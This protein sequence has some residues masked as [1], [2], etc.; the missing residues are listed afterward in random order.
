MGIFSP[1][2]HNSLDTA[3]ENSTGGGLNEATD[4]S[5]ESSNAGF[6]EIPIDNNSERLGNGSNSDQDFVVVDCN[7]EI[8]S[9]QNPITKI[10]VQNINDGIR[11]SLNDDDD[12]SVS[13]PFKLRRLCPGSI[14]GLYYTLNLCSMFY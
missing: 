8:N 5:A 12:S 11:T 9:I 7:V 4:G 14:I 2:V 1:L 10:E 3:V 6:I 13:D